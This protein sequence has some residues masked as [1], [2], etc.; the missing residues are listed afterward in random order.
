MPSSHRRFGAVVLAAACVTAAGAAPAVARVADGPRVKRI[1]RTLKEVPPPPRNIAKRSCK[2]HTAKYIRSRRTKQYA[3]GGY[4]TTIRYCRGKVKIVRVYKEKETVVVTVPV[5]VPVPVPGPTVEVPVTKPVRLTLLHANDFESKMRTGDS[6]TG[7][8]GAARFATVVARLRREAENYSDAALEAGKKTKGSLLV[9]SGDNFLAG[10]NYQAGVNQNAGTFYDSYVFS[11]LGFDAATIGNHEFDFGPARA[12]DFI[13]QD[14]SGA[15]FLSASLDFSASPDLQALV[16]SGRVRSSVVVEKGGRRIGIIGISP[17]ELASISSPAPVV[18][19][20]TSVPEIATV[21]NAEAAK[22]DA[23]GVNIVILSSHMQSNAADRQLLPLLRGIDIDIAGGGDDLLANPDDTL[24]PGATAVGAYPSLVDDADGRAVPVVTTQGEYRYVGRL[25]AEFDAA[26]KLTSVDDGRSGPVRVSGTA[27]QPDLAAEDQ[28]LKA[29]VTDPLNAY[30]ASLSANVIATSDV[31]LDGRNASGETIR[32]RETNLGDL[33]ADSF[34]FAGRRDATL[35]SRPQ[36]DIALTNSG[37]IRNS[38]ILPAGDITEKNTFQVLPFDNTTVTVPNLSR[39]QFKELLEHG[40]AT[41]A[42]AASNGRFPQIA[43]FKVV[44]D[45]REQAQVTDAAG[46]VTTPGQRVRTVTLI[47]PD[48]SPGAAIVTAGAVVPGA[49]LTLVTNNFTAAG[50]DGYPFRG[51]PTQTL[52]PSVGYQQ[53]LFDFITAP[54][55]DG[56]LEGTISG[57]DYPCGAVD[58]ITNLDPAYPAYPAG[59]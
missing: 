16:D 37:G 30:D 28:T 46:V 9:S 31:G 58:R 20:A 53:A 8:G 44:Y 55:A 50:G 14:T 10:I 5:P 34:L 47:N 49:A 36:P 27:G 32:K 40:F 11:R 26:G 57:T 3:G 35:N 56:G 39:A 15:P 1:S 54:A 45:S 4:R 17:P 42:P 6:M 13:E 29:S 48:G 24:I 2:G 12:A 38:S 33:V 51:I 41:V 23:A 19:T 7:Y 22:L 21:V 52:Q 43:G 25:T 18:Q 59:C